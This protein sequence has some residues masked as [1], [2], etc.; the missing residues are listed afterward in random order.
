MDGEI[1]VFGLA[2]MTQGAT[3]KCSIACL[4]TERIR[5]ILAWDLAYMYAPVV[6]IILLTK[7]LYPSYHSSRIQN[8]RRRRKNI[9]LERF[10]PERFDPER[11]DPEWLTRS[12]FLHSHRSGSVLTLMH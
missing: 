2:I 7:E 4:N 6:E 8:L 3:S 12:S 5:A 11:F 9:S 10:D 1:Q